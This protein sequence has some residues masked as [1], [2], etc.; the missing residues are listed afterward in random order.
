MIVFLSFSAIL[1]ICFTAF[2]LTACGEKLT[3]DNYYEYIDIQSTIKK[4]EIYDNHCLGADGILYVKGLSSLYDYSNI[5]LVVT[6]TIETAYD[7]EINKEKIHLSILGLLID[8]HL[9]GNHRLVHLC[10]AHVIKRRKPH[11]NKKQRRERIEQHILANRPKN[12][13]PPARRVTE[14]GLCMTCS[15][16]VGD[17]LAFSHLFQSRRKRSRV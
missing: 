4:D 7:S 10:K 8:V 15:L 6:V 1:F 3:L 11:S 16:V 2:T 13:I 14:G 5:D 9:T 12:C 17:I